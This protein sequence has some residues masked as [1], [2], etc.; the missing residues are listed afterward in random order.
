MTFARDQSEEVKRDVVS[1]L[2]TAQRLA[3]SALREDRKMVLVDLDAC[4]CSIALNHSDS[5]A[6]SQCRDAKGFSH[7]MNASLSEYT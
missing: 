7:F 5:F 1:Y 6:G 3:P 4:D 2:A